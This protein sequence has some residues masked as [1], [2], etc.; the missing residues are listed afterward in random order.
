MTHCEH[1]GVSF[2]ERLRYILIDAKFSELLLIPE[3][4]RP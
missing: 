3:E 2:S 1:D 4:P